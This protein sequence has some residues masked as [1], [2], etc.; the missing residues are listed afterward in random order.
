MR[1][2]GRIKNIINKRYGIVRQIGI[3]SK[4]TNPLCIIFD[5]NTSR[6]QDKKSFI[7]ERYIDALVFK[8]SR[9]CLDVRRYKKD[10]EWR[11]Y[12]YQQPAKSFAFLSLVCGCDLVVMI[13][14][15]QASCPGSN[16]GIRT[17]H[18]SSSSAGV[19]KHGQRR[20]T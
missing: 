18:G 5:T 2:Y 20:R 8:F 10:Y 3:D 15:L 4:A 19:A 6:Y 11:V 13:E 1:A 9:V 17:R 7:L 14:A 12:V 16:P